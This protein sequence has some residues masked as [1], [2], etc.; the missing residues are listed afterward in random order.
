MPNRVLITGGMGFIGTSV[1]RDL[2]STGDDVQSIDVLIKQA[3]SVPISKELA[4]LNLEMDIRETALLTKA[5]EAYQPNIL[6]HLASETGT[7]Q[8]FFNPKLH[9]DTN[10]NGTASVIKS[11]IDSNIQLDYVLLAS[12]RA[13]YGEGS[14]VD[15][16]GRIHYPNGRSV[17]QL[18]K[19]QWE[20]YGLEYVLSNVAKNVAN[21]TSIYG[22]TKYTQE[23][24]LRN[25]ALPNGVPLG[26]FRLQN[27]YGIGQDSENPYTGII[28]IFI[29]D[30]L[31]N[32][33][34][35]VY[36]DGEIT[37]DFIYIDDVTKM[38]VTALNL[39]LEG[40]FD[41]GTGVRTSLIQLANHVS[42]I[43]DSQPPHI[44]GNFRIGDVRHAGCEEVLL[45]EMLGIYPVSLQVGLE[46][47]I[48]W[49]KTQNR[50][51]GR[52]TNN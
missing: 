46:S 10:V 24:L 47:L 26:I 17:D 36:E 45:K 14:Y 1:I 28:N 23:L 43:L 27:V 25:W 6:I 34:I 12:S 32:K 22:T 16:Q 38:I 37:R 30:A 13:V 8:S 11:L 42:E 4:P 49:I 51:L 44:S 3:H 20:F 19:K 18:N 52:E 21:P 35:N 2:L 15:V 50:I 29:Q 41:V 9:T 31:K 7:S 5:I 48:P 40:N 33:S 39:K